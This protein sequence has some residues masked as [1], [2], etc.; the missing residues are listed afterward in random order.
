M[1]VDLIVLFQC[2]SY[3]SRRTPWVGSGDWNSATSFPSKRIHK[4]WRE[5]SGG[6]GMN[7]I[8]VEF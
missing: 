3:T 2:N 6:V 7:L 1:S 8:V 4:T 5:S